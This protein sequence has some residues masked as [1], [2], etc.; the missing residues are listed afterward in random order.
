MSRMRAFAAA[1]AVALLGSGCA[2]APKLTTPTLS[3][4]GVRL[5]GSDLLTQHLKVRVHVINPND[6]TLPVKGIDYTLE[7]DG[8]PFATGESAASFVVPAL[9]EAEFD[10]NVTTNMAGML[11]RLLARGSDAAANVP[12]R[13]AGKISLSQ[14]WLQ[15]IPFEQHGT[16]R[17][18]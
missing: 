5:E 12:Y 9:G 13:L 1:A 10:M 15:S 3:I 7:V 14:G 8:Q 18:Q 11:V 4:V 2:L 16:F 17:L 6:R